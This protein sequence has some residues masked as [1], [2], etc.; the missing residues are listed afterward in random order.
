MVRI[1]RAL[2]P[3]ARAA[4]AAGAAY[5]AF[6]IV[7]AAPTSLSPARAIPD[8][9]DPLHLAWVMAWD[10]HQLV[11]HPFSLFDANTFYPYPRSLAFGDHLL[12]EALLGAPV[13]WL[14]GNAVL[15]SNLVVLLALTLSA[16]AIFIL[17]RDVTHSSAVAFLAGLAYAFNTFTR[18]EILRVQVLNIE[19]WP[20]VFLFLERL[21]RTGRARYAWLLGGSLLLQGLSGAYYLV[22]SALLAPV[23][24]L[25]AYLGARRRPSVAELA[26]LGAALLAAGLVALPVLWPYAVQLRTMGFEKPLKIGV[27]VLSYLDPVPSSSFLGRFRLL[28]PH[29]DVPHF[30]GFLGVGFMAVGSLRV[31]RGHLATSGRIAGLL[32]L[33]TALAGFVLS[34][35]PAIV[36]HGRTLGP[37]PYAL[38]YRY[39]PLSRGMSSPVRAAVLVVLGGAVLLGLGLE[40]LLEALPPPS[41]PLAVGLLALLLPLEHWSPPTT[42]VA[43]PTGGE[44]P[45][46]Y[47]FLAGEPPEPMVDL[48]LYPDVA[49]RLWAVYPYLSTYHWRPIPIGRTSFYPPAHDY[50]AWSLRDFPDDLS[51]GLLDRLGIRTLVVHP[52]VWEDPELR[53]QKLA[54]LERDPRLTLVRHFTDV[55]P[56]RD[57]DLEL[58]DERVYRIVGAPR[59][60]PPPCTPENEVDREGWVLGGSGI[61]SG[62]RAVDGDRR[63]AWFTA[64]PQTPGDR[65]E[66]TLP[67]AETLSAVAVDMWYPHT[68]FARNLVLVLRGSEGGWHRVR[69]ADGPQERGALIAALVS[70]PREASMVLRFAPES[71]KAFRLMVGWRE[72]DPSWPA[73]SVP[74]LHAYREC[75]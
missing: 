52:F 71:V 3:S 44:I 31:L 68:E 45:A 17:M 12:P 70:R 65:L 55:P 26:G 38:L 32:G 58:G 46:A 34:L 35:G 36:F 25:V 23:W 56:P 5:A 29:A 21:A 61:V 59:A 67:R 51:I 16:T 22:Y 9:G 47:A 2:P 48:P 15:S 75:R 54:F 7:W 8:L 49:K 42:G 50:L 62:K 63:T 33:A 53:E 41:R 4:A 64:S 28:P 6:A 60:E 19:W 37:G 30:L 14:T 73:F 24:L 18:S 66:V 69:Y 10:A 11:R 40:A 72:A 74:E 57:R 27:D 39:V 20:F 13:F 1:L 43:V